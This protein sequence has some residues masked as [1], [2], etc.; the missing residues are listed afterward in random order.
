VI[1]ISYK[2]GSKSPIPRRCF[3]STLGLI[4]VNSPNLPTRP[5]RRVDQIRK[6]DF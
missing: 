2:R 3:E 1:I 4:Y 6:L 5:N